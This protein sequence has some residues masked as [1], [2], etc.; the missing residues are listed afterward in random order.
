MIRSH[1]LVTATMALALMLAAT[2]VWL[3]TLNLRDESSIVDSAL[4]FGPTA[5]QIERGEYLARAGDCMACHTARGGA[6]Y[7]GG[8]GIDTPFGV[9]YASNL[10][11]DTETGLGAWTPAYFWRALHNGRSKDGRLL[12]PAFPYT[13]FTKVTRDDADALFAFLQ[14]L[15]PV[16][17]PNRPHRLR[18]PYDSQLALAAWR[19]LYFEP[20]AYTPDPAQTAVW[21]RGAYLVRGL[22]HCNACHA[23]RNGLGAT[24]PGPEL[25]GGLIPM[26][27]WY[28]PSLASAQEAGV[29]QWSDDDVIALLK[30]GVCAQGSAL[31]PM[32]E[33]VYRS[34][35]HLDAQDLLAIATFVK[36]IA[37]RPS[38]L[39]APVEPQEPTANTDAEVIRRGA[40]LYEAQCADCHG[41][42]G[43]GAVTPAGETAY[44][45]L[46]GNRA[47]TM[48]PPAN[49]IRV[50]ANGG[51]A[52]STQG[53]P[54]PFGMPPFSQ[55][56]PDSDIAAVLT[57]IR[58]AW[59]DQAGAVS[60]TE[61]Q[62]YRKGVSD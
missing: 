29:A 30:N 58:S 41:S 33:V 43:E 1:Q 21:N 15:P 22:A 53:H 35:Q 2:G 16:N 62:R 23:S 32:A 40:K 25:G 24:D 31:G 49:L 54:R 18:F 5:Q 39:A 17:Q 7:A 12:Y 56:L 19:A 14:S 61:L 9:V 13:E 26:Q 59:G 46:A 52:P 57:F 28:A 8:R 60:M 4:P 20:G 34:T 50:V 42:H 38:A 37:Q 51:F 47:V 36:A 45:P 11:P 10:T 6:L 3:V 27:N 44:P 48:N 55:I